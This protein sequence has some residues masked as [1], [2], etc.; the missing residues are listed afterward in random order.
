MNALDKASSGT[1]APAGAARTPGGTSPRANGNA[2]WGTEVAAIDKILTELTATDTATGTGAMTGTTGASG[3]NGPTG[4]AGSRS[5]AATAVAL[6]DATL[7][8]LMEVRTHVVAFATAMSA[9]QTAPKGHD[10]A[11]AGD[12]PAA[13]PAA[14]QGAPSEPQ[15]QTTATQSTTA[16]PQSPTTAADATNA[17]APAAAAGAAAPQVDQEA[18][19]RHLMAARDSLAELTKLPAAA[20]LQ[21]DARTQVSQLISNF[22]ELIT[23][24]SNWTASYAKVEANLNAL[25]GPETG[26]AAAMAATP[27][28]ETNAAPAATAT[29]GANTD[30]APTAVGT[31][32]TATAELDPAVRA[33]LIDLRRN[34]SEFQKAAGAVK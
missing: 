8:K 26:D 13:A 7:A 29:T 27:A 32:G 25:L 33:K 22:N 2:N 10:Q 4:M 12:A 21:G 20:Q 24:Q 3:S 5:K 16:A 19:R 15:S 31:S 14:T 11:S 6:D 1:A 34:L 17:Q 9:P 28:P 23:T 30:P 18:V